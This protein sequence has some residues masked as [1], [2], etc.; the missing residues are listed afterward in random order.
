[1]HPP[2]NTP[3]DPDMAYQSHAKSGRSRH[4][5]VAQPATQAPARTRS[6][7]LRVAKIPWASSS[8]PPS[9]STPT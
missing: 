5:P 2:A 8:F 3:R 9:Y 7:N 4:R 6:S 1:M